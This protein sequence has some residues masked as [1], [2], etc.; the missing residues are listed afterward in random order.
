VIEISD[1]SQGEV[2]LNTFDFDPKTSPKRS[3]RLRGARFSGKNEAYQK[4]AGK[5]LETGAE[6][7]AV[8]EVKDPLTPTDVLFNNEAC[9]DL[10]EVEEKIGKL[11]KMM[12]VACNPGVSNLSTLTTCATSK[13]LIN[14]AEKMAEENS[15]VTVIV[16]DRFSY[17]LGDKGSEEGHTSVYTV[18]GEESLFAVYQRHCQKTRL[19]PTGK[20]L[21]CDGR[22][23][24]KSMTVASLASK[25]SDNTV[26]IG[27]FLLEFD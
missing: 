3:V 24:F 25:Y 1:S 8:G 4:V 20:I 27:K 13:D 6:T 21:T 15:P 17:Y 2:D 5:Q 14:L 9:V 7:G 16:V 11:R 12:E 18:D 22:K 10:K 19:L 26:K 23:L